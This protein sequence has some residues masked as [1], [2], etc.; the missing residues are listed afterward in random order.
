M[1][2][3]AKIINQYEPVAIV[4]KVNLADHAQ[5]WA[6]ASTPAKDVYF[7]PFFSIILGSIKELWERGHR[8]KIEVIFDRQLIFEP[9]VKTWYPVVKDIFQRL[10]DPDIS[11]ALS[12]MPHEPIFRCDED[13]LPLQAADLFAYCFRL[14][15]E[16]DMPLHWMAAEMPK[17]KLSK[18]SVL[19]N[20]ERMQEAITRGKITIEKKQEIFT[21]EIV[22]SYRKQI[23]REQ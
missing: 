6:K 14:A 23:K 7:L 10:N 2:K 8:E 12:L 18:Q 20:K 1:R 5:T 9:R 19:W 13:F 15:D 21:S 16:P 4:T 3:L 11:P 22:E 17:V